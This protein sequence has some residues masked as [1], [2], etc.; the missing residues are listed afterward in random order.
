MD[1][2]ALVLKIASDLGRIKTSDIVKELHDTKSRQYVNTVVRGMVNKKLLL[3]GGST[4]GSFYVL[5]QNIHLL[6]DEVVVKLKRENLE[7]HKVFNDL[8]EKAPFINDLEENVSSILFYAFTEM[9]NNAIEHSRSKYVEIR[10]RKDKENIVFIINDFGIGVF[11]NV[12]EKRRLKSELEAIQDLLKGKTTTQPHSHT[13]EGI[14]FTSKVADLY[15]LES[16]GYRLRVDNLVK[17]VFIEP[18]TPQKRGTKVTFKLTLPSK[19]HLNDVFSQFVAEPGEIGFDKTE[20][21]VRLFTS[22]TV[23]ISRSQARRILA[24]LDKFKTI[25]FDFDKVTTVGQ[26]FADEIFRVFQ[27][28]HPDISIQSI[29]MIEPVKFMVDRVDKTQ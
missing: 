21:K 20:I 15:L 10:I 17:D 3:K 26:A 2:E 29:N 9:L 24:G 14:F 22:G 5:P 19:K 18:L 16:F 7:E 25:V 4:A 28:R 23:Y 8:A 11:R 1:L 12:M 13:G 6:G 27:Q